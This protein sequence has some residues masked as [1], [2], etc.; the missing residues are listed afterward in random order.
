M[1]KLNCHNCIHF[2]ITWDQKS[3]KGCKAYNFKSSQMPSILVKQSSGAECT[4]FKE[5][6]PK[7]KEL[8]L[9]SDDL[10]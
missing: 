4:L 1:D 7:K 2:H 10:W 6:K 8:D 5:K 9:S 3:P